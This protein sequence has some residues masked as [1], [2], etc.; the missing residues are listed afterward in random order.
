VDTIAVADPGD[1]RA[2]FDRCAATGFPE[3][4]GRPARLLAY[5]LRLIRGHARLGPEDTVLDLG[6]GTGHHLVG[7]APRRGLGI[8]LSPGM[9]ALAR[10]SAGGQTQLSFQVDDATR[11]DGVASA[12]VDV[13]LCIG[14]LEHIVDKAAVLASAHRVLRPGGRFLC[15]TPDGA[16][17]WYRSVA[18]RL[19]VA[20]RHLS[21]DRFLTR[22]ELHTLLKG[23]AF[24]RV[25]LGAW[26][27]IPRGDMPV[28]ARWLFGALAGLRLPGLR[29]G[30][31]ACGGKDA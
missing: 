11:L 6:C 1:V 23:A 8:D 12:S 7:L 25:R 15:L 20:T 13:A 18:P 17:P 5:R 10:R 9:I 26:S 27:F 29:G 28:P 30:L 14:V 2:F 3:P 16:H 24:S 21:T 22:G 19:G 31:W 4:H